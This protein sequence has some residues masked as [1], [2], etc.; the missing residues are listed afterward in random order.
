MYYS[1]I[2]G[3]MIFD[4]WDGAELEKHQE[5]A[6]GGCQCVVEPMEDNQVKIVKLLSSNPSDFMNPQYQPGTIIK[7]SPE[8]L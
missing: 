3:E 6:I 7:F 2:P 8:I 4:E 1:I 5:M